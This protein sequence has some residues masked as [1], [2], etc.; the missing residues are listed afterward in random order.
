V[1]DSPS[2]V[3][4]ETVL[5]EFRSPQRLWSRNEVLG[6]PSPVPAVNGIYAWFFKEIPGG[7]NVAG[8]VRVEGL[9]LM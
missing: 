3:S 9:T 2:E 1:T 5:V 7:A 6:A 4:L 8:C